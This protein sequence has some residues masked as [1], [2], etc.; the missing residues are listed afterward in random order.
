MLS[1]DADS[2]NRLMAD[3]CLAFDKP[4]TADLIRVFAEALKDVSFHDV[5][6]MAEQHRRTGKRFPSPAM[7]RPERASAARSTFKADPPMS[8]WAIAANKILFALAYLDKRRGF[9][10]ICTYEPMP[11]G[12]YGLPV[13]LV[14][15][16]DGSLLRRALQVKRDY[17]QMAE[18]AE[19]NGEPMPTREFNAMC[20][21]GFEKILATVTSPP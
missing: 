20:R 7:L 16:T 12:G 5:K 18:D 9:K 15:P 6:R 17:V 1:S 19:R 8:T 13:R 4:C 11:A 3:L 21:E 14:Q 10:P 2:F